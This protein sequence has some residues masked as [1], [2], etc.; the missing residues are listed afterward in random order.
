MIDKIEVTQTEK[1][2]AILKYGNF[3]T[4][5]FIGKNGATADKIEGDKKTPLG[6]FDL[7]ICFGTHDKEEL[8]INNELEY[9]KINQNQYWVDD[10]NSKYYNQLVDITKIEKDWNSAEHLIKYEKQYEY[11]IEIKSNPNNI[12]NKGSA[13]FIHCSVNKPTAG[14]VAIERNKMKELLSLINNNTKILIKIK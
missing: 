14:C 3:V 4:E 12:P 5:A 11:A 13:V 6:M 8:K 10:S 1:N 9:L 2:K 7:G